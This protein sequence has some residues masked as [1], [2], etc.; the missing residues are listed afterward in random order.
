MSTFLDETTPP[1]PGEEL[2]QNALAG[3]LRETLSLDTDGLQIEQFPGGHSN[4]TYL[5]RLADQELV[6]R[7]PPFGSHVKSAHDMSREHFVLSRLA[8]VFP[9]APAPVHF[10]QDP[11]I[12]G[13]AFYLMKRLRGVILRKKVPKTMAFDETTARGLA[14]ALIN[15]LVDLH[16][17]DVAAAGLEELGRPDGYVERQVSGWT[18]RYGDAQTD[19]IAEVDQVARWLAEAIP[20]SPAPALIH[21]DFKFD[22]LVLDPDDITRVIGV[23]DWE[24]AT[25]GDPLMDLGTALSYWIEDGDPPDLK[26]LAFGPTAKPGM[27]RRVELVELYAERSGRT[28][29]NM[30]FYYCFGLFK[31]AVVV[32]QIY[33]R[34][35]QGSTADERFATLKPAVGLLIRQAANTIEADTL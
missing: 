32:Q 25:F 8:P 9:R 27:P 29:D 33:H 26:R 19:E 12:I 18:R 5:L 17:V 22:N 7:R 2:D 13:D 23:L 30:V 11:S 6:L 34:Y 24:M 31:L 20:S 16:G 14:D 15:L 35:R 28:A 4:L 21:N 3:Y 10:C 1:R